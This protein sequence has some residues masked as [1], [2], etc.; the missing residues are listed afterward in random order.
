MKKTSLIICCL[1]TFFINAQSQDWSFVKVQRQLDILYTQRNWQEV[2]NYGDSALAHGLDF[3]QLRTQ[4]GVSY[5]MEKRFFK[6]AAYLEKALSLDQGNLLAR[7]Y[8]YYT[9]VALER[10]PDALLLTKGQTDAFVQYLH[11]KKTSVLES[12]YLEGGG[13]MSSM[14]DTAAG[15][16]FGSLNLGH[17]LGRTLTL[18]HS[19]SMIRLNY[20]GNDIRQYEYVALVPWAFANGW[21]LSVGGHFSTTKSRSE[22]WLQPTFQ[23]PVQPPRHILSDIRENYYGGMLS[24][25][26]TFGRFSIK[27]SVYVGVVVNHTTQEVDIPDNPFVPPSQVITETN[28]TKQVYQADLGMS[29]TPPILGDR[30]KLG[31][32]LVTH[33]GS[34]NFN[35]GARAKLRVT[36]TP[37]LYFTGEYDYYGSML[38]FMEANGFIYHNSVAALQDKLSLTGYWL[39]NKNVGFLLLGQWENRKDSDLS[40]FYYTFAGGIS[41]KL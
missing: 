2:I 14:P 15:V 7:E 3:A 30:L 20:R 23:P 8:L 38:N 19:F 22:L 40:F 35:L 25:Q 31:A 34:D 39:L 9:Y 26:K 29:W 12:L 1:L 13:K 33:L 11:A 27:P 32:D 10:E 16:G 24:L 17:R 4:V 6:S 21:Q 28:T 37:R 18:T 41:I 5:F 36:A